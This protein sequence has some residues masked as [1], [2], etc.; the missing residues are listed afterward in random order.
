MI[1]RHPR[2][3]QVEYD[4][5]CQYDSKIMANRSKVLTSR[6]SS[7]LV[8]KQDHLA[9]IQIAQMIT[10]TP[11]ARASILDFKTEASFH[12]PLQTQIES[13]NGSGT[14]YSN[15]H[16]SPRLQ[17]ADER[18][19]IMQD[20]FPE[21]FLQKM[22]T[23]PD[24]SSTFSL[25]PKKLVSSFSPSSSS[26]SISG[27]NPMNTS[28]SQEEEEG[29]PCR[30]ID[31]CKWSLLDETVGKYE[32]HR[33]LRRKSKQFKSR[34]ITLNNNQMDEYESTE[35]RAC[36]HC[37]KRSDLD[38]VETERL[39]LTGNSFA[40]VAESGKWVIKIQGDI[41]AKEQSTSR[42][43]IT[44]CQQG[45][46]LLQFEQFERMQIWL[47]QL[48]VIFFPRQFDNFINLLTH[49]F[50]PQSLI[51]QL[52]EIE[53][54]FRQG[55]KAVLTKVDIHPSKELRL[56]HEPSSVLPKLPPQ[57][58][59]IQ[60]S[61]FNLMNFC[62]VQP[63]TIEE[64]TISTSPGQRLSP[65]KS[66]TAKQKGKWRE[67]LDSPPKMDTLQSHQG[68][69]TPLKKVSLS[70]KPTSSSDLQQENQ[71]PISQCST[72]CYSGHQSNFD[73]S[74]SQYS[75]QWQSG[76]SS[77]ATSFDTRFSP[78]SYHQSSSSSDCSPQKRK[79][80]PAKL[81]FQSLKQAIICP[82]ESPTD[83]DSSPVF[84][85]GPKKSQVINDE[86]VDPFQ[87]KP[88][89]KLTQTSSA[90]PSPNQDVPS[91]DSQIGLAL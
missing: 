14:F 89:I 7:E 56:G 62:N 8:K 36:L 3:Q 72:S 47:R 76:Q 28:L 51:D 69:K 88:L 29:F 63:D 34:R 38:S 18:Q 77:P 84:F 31:K 80:I 50:S 22:V 74:P 64:L 53:K 79:K 11:S 45:E 82:I 37:F 33:G 75:L 2:S 71:S 87:S 54:D 24:A 43:S 41:M 5:A 13:P 26:P 59:E 16:I 17:G 58:E 91:S 67:Q 39:L 68:K 10:S 61:P 60:V 86:N 1:P 40:A 85:L 9:S 48:K 4:E 55:P 6:R 70:L 30:R 23:M 15:R 19:Y 32:D 90:T 35:L 49:I 83:P 57:H 25:S 44:T 66:Y 46:W 27:F 21:P 78:I 42:K 52:A 20:R 73:T 12:G 81:E 65:Q